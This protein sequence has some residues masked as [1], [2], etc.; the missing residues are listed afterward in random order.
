MGFLSKLFG[1]KEV[2]S[3]E[4]KE[5][6]PVLVENELYEPGIKCGYCGLGIHGEQQIKTYNGKKFHLKPCFRDMRKEAKKLAFH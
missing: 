3:I 2:E 4:E 5:Q 1:K 6:E